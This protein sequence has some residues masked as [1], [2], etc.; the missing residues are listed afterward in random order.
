MY[1]DALVDRRLT[2]RITPLKTSSARL[3]HPYFLRRSG[4]TIGAASGPSSRAVPSSG[5]PRMRPLPS[6]G[7]TRTRGSLLIRFTFQRVAFALAPYLH[8]DGFA[9]RDSDLVSVLALWEGRSMFYR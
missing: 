9:S 1:S 6:L 8:F 4:S 2:A 5:S 3:T 7:V